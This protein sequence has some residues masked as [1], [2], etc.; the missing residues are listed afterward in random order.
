MS[1]AVVSRTL[2]VLPGKVW[3]SELTTELERLGIDPER[4]PI[5][6]SKILGRVCR[7]Q[8]YLNCFQYDE[9]LE[10]TEE[11]EPPKRRRVERRPAK[12]ES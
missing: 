5:S 7:H 8:G 10:V 3:V 4:A 2:I 11:E 6:A 9:E 12:V 1:E